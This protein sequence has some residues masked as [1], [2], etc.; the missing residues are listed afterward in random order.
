MKVT[1]KAG[2]EKKLLNHYPYGHSADIASAD[3]GLGFGEVADVHAESGA[4]VGRGYFNEHGA[5]P[6]R[7]LTLKR[8]NIDQ[9]F[10]EKRI[11]RA[12][13]RRKNIS[14]TNAMRVLHAEADG[15]PGVV[16]DKFGDVLS[17]QMRS[18]GVERHRDMILAALKKV[19][20]LS[21]AYERSDTLERRKEGLELKTGTLWGEIPKR[22][23]FFEDDLELFF[24][25]WE[26]QKTG[27]FL[28]QR[29]N[30]RLMREKVSSG[31]NF[32]DVYSY[33]GGF[34]LQAARAGATS[35]ALDKDAN[36][37]KTLEAVARANGLER[38][39]GVRLGDALASLAQLE[40]EKRRFHN[41]IFDPPTL[42]K[43]KDEVAGAKRI[44]VD[45]VSRVLRMLEPGGHLMVSSCAHY[46][47]LED[48]LDACRLA[49]GLA[50]REAEVLTVTYQGAD[51]P[52]MLLVPES[53]Y[54]KSV[55][56]RVE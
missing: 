15:M 44:F 7:M 21:A 8:E 22:I 12:L 32:L 16:A 11:A 13:E 3:S 42:A 39:T 54:L 47:R 6:L 38:Q 43:R 46:L 10:Y 4:F 25:P 14:G 40:Q 56:L 19:T 24:D 17:V 29:D 18:A 26:G 49:C 23:E 35:L 33:T 5:T 48:M 31:Q 37:L 52:W 34:G 28:D 20:G 27:Y 41:A 30:R 36:A 45:G 9:A 50:E 51:H 1:L 55:M 2:K 53:L